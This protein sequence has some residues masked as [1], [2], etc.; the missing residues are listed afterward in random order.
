MKTKVVLNLKSTDYNKI[1]L[2]YI[3]TIQKPQKEKNQTVYLTKE[4][5]KK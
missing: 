4:Y 2:R 3:V 5:S 1:G